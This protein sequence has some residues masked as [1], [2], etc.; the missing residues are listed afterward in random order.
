VLA[1]V[2][3]QLVVP[4]AFAITLAAAS[5]AFAQ[6]AADHAASAHGK[7]IV[8]GDPVQPTPSVVEER[9]RHHKE[10]LQAERNGSVRPT[11]ANPPPL[12]AEGPDARGSGK[13]P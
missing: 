12:P 3:R 2:T 9:L 1:G 7:P 5:G 6:S 8:D 11:V 13:K 4:A 10:M